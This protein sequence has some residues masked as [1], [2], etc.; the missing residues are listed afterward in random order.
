MLA[1]L[2]AQKRSN[3]LFERF[4]GVLRQTP[5]P[6]GFKTLL[7]APSWNMGNANRLGIV[8]HKDPRTG[9]YRFPPRA[10]APVPPGF[11]KVE[12]DNMGH[13]RRV[14]REMAEIARKDLSEKVEGRRV[15]HDAMHANGVRELS[16]MKGGFSNRGR[17]FADYAIQETTRKQLAKPTRVTAPDVGFDALNYNKSNREG[18]RDEDGRTSKNY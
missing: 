12:V 13:A 16:E 9:K 3:E 15:V 17:R 5:P 7:A 6:L 14:E 1:L 11:E 10:D 8:V 4:N 2:A 18:H